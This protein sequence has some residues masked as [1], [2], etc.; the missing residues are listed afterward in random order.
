MKRWQ[1]WIQG[2]FYYT[3]MYLQISITRIKKLGVSCSVVL[4]LY[5][6]RAKSASTHAKLKSGWF[7]FLYAD[8]TELSGM[9]ETAL[10]KYRNILID[11]GI[12]EMK[13]TKTIPKQT[14]Y[15]INLFKMVQY[16]Y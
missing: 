14:L 9:K 13:I 7:T 6:Y 10:R 15:R 12:L 16:E 3:V 4:A 11:K 8:Q 5:E 2:L 1:T